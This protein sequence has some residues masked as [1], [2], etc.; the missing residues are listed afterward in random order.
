MKNG[1]RAVRLAMLAGA[2]GVAVTSATAGA[3]KIKVPVSSSGSAGDAADLFGARPA[4]SDPALSPDGTKLL[5]LAADRA[6]GTQLMVAAADGSTP[7]KS[8]TASDGHPMQLRWCDWADNSRIVCSAIG[9]DTFNG[10]LVGFQRLLSVNSANGELK[11]LSQ[12]GADDKRVRMSQFDGDVID[13][14]QGEQGRLLMMRDHVPEEHDR[15]PS[16]KERQRAGRR[17]D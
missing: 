7:P 12:Q 2:M 8:V 15:N 13:W 10:D 9:T 3:P 16:G 1:L 17:S 14:L 6:T 11:L 4:I 5:Y